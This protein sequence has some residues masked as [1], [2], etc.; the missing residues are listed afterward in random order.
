MILASF[1]ERGS[2]RQISERQKGDFD[3]TTTL[4]LKFF[5][6]TRSECQKC[7]FS[8]SLLLNQNVE[9]NIKIKTFDVLILPMDSKKIRTSKIKNINYLWRITY[10]SQGLWGVRLGSIRLG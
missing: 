10:G 6:T 5:T 4:S 1:I 9:K 2:E 3:T 7:L 8:F